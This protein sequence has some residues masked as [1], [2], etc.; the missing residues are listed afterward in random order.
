MNETSEM[1]RQ[2]IAAIQELVPTELLNKWISEQV[3]NVRMSFAEQERCFFYPALVVVKLGNNGLETEVIVLPDIFDENNRNSRFSN[4]QKVGAR[5]Y[6]EYGR[7]IAVILI[8]ESWTKKFRYTDAVSSRQISDYADKSEEMSITAGT[9][10]KRLAAGFIEIN[11]DKNNNIV[12]GDA[13]YVL[14]TKENPEAVTSDLITSFWQGYT[15]AMLYD[16]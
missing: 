12:L 14:S 5:C 10:D 3:E 1:V 9:I 2:V 4:F 7:V 16:R 11:R 8:T 15:K 13:R 6:K